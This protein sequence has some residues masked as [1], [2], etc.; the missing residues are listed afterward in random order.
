[1]F[2]EISYMADITGDC[3][4]NARVWR[5]TV[6]N[7]QSAI[8]Y[9]NT[10][11]ASSLTSNIWIFIIKWL[12]IFNLEPVAGGDRKTTDEKRVLRQL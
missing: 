11:Q 3:C 4:P 6:Q 1:M 8:L 7:T 5:A 9:L 12:V 2:V 10:R